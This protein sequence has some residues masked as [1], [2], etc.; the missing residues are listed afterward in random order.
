MYCKF[1]VLTVLRIRIRRIH[2]FQGLQNPD[3]RV[4]GADPAL[5]PDPY[6]IR[7]HFD[8]FIF[9]KLCKYTFKKAWVRGSGSGSIPK[10]H[11]SATLV[12]RYLNRHPSPP[13]LQHTTSQGSSR[14]CILK[15]ES[16]NPPISGATCIIF[17]AI[18]EEIYLI[19]SI[20][21]SLNKKL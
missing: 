8:F 7:L 6:I 9:E 13:L 5:A 16:S 2:I 21:Y 14:T 10:C 1:C 17:L 4:I 20:Y 11:G 3:L 18:K 12:C 19:I 15:R